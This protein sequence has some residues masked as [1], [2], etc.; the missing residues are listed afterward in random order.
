M[1]FENYETWESIIGAFYRLGAETEWVSKLEVVQELVGEVSKPELSV[2]IH[3]LINAGVIVDDG[4]V[5][6][7]RYFML[8]SKA[9]DYVD[10]EE[11]L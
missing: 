9:W 8:T 11:L 1:S 6:D 4:G 3:R 10:R 2:L 7:G 5:G